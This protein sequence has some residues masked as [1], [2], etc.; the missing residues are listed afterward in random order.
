MKEWWKNENDHEM[1]WTGDFETPA[2]KASWATWLLQPCLQS[3][4][5]LF[6]GGAMTLQN[7]T[8]GSFQP[9][10]TSKK[11]APWGRIWVP[12]WCPNANYTLLFNI[13]QF[14]YA[15]LLM[16]V[17]LRLVSSACAKFDKFFQHLRASAL[18][19][20]CLLE[21]LSS[22]RAALSSRGSSARM[23]RVQIE[24]GF[25]GWT[26]P[27]HLFPQLQRSKEKRKFAVQYAVWRASQIRCILHLQIQ[28]SQALRHFWPH[29]VSCFIPQALS[30]EALMCCNW[31]PRAIWVLNLNSWISKLRAECLGHVHGW[32][33]YT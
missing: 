31:G 28:I 16:P 20:C 12:Q 21:Q 14:D 32:G 23:G 33:E 5:L 27:W 17:S 4:A 26:P 9:P 11:Q 10:K 7:W 15:R 18:Q 29:G 19:L 25:L 3:L 30:K 24:V 6:Q 2:G 8:I 1:Y 13:F 22:G